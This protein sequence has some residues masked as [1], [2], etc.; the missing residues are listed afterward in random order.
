MMERNSRQRCFDE[1]S[2]VIYICPVQTRDKTM[3]DTKKKDDS[4]KTKL[5]IFGSA[6]GV[7]MIGGLLLIAAIVVLLILNRH[8]IQAAYDARLLRDADAALRMSRH[9][10]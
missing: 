4:S 8:K 1:S 7:L 6:W 3:S 10:Y 5:L 2:S 9:L